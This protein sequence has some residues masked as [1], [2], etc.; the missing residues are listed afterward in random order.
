MFGRLIVSATWLAAF[1]ALAELT[2]TANAVTLTND[3]AWPTTSASNVLQTAFPVYDGDE[4]DVKNGRKHRQSFVL[5]SSL[6]FDSILFGGQDFNPEAD[7]FT[8]GFYSIADPNSSEQSDYETDSLTP[9]VADFLVDVSNGTAFSGDHVLKIGLDSAVTLPAGSYYMAVDSGASGTYPFKWDIVFGDPYPAGRGVVNLNA[10]NAGLEFSM[11]LITGADYENVWSVDGDGSFHDAANWTQG[12]VPTDDAIFGSALS[13]ANAPATITVDTP[14]SLNSLTFQNNSSYVVAG[15]GTITLTGDHEVF[16]PLG[17]HLLSTDLAGNV[18]LMKTGNGTLGLSGA[19]SYTGTTVVQA[20]TLSI[21]SLAAIDNQSAIPLNIAGGAAV[22]LYP[23]VSG[24]LSSELTGAG[25]LRMTDSL[26]ATNAADKVTVSRSNSTFTGIVRVEGG[27]LEISNE[28]ALGEGGSFEYRTVIDDGKSGT[29]SLTGNISIADEFLDFGGRITDDV[30]LSSSGNNAWNGIIRGGSTYNAGDNNNSANYHIE[31][32]SGTLTLQQLYAQ[33]NGHDIDFVFSGAGDT[34]IAGHISDSSIDDSGVVSFSNR[35]D[36]AVTKRGTGT[37]TINTGTDADNTN[38]NNWWFGPTV[39][40]EGTLVVNDPLASDVGELHSRD[41][42]V[43][44]GGTLDVT[45]FNTYSQQIGQTLRGSGTIAA[46][47]LALYDDGSLSPGNSNGQVGT[48]QVNGNVTLGAFATIGTEGAWS[49]DIG[50]S[51]SPESDQLA[52]SGTFTAS[53]SP[54]MMV[55]VTPSAGHLDQGSTTIVAHT[56][57]TNTAMNGVA[58]QITDANGTPL[59]TRQT[60]S[61]S[62]D[63]AG[64]VNLTVTGEEANRTWSGATSGVWDIATTNNWQ[65]GDQQFRDLDQVTFDDSAA[66][67]TN[68]TVDGSRFAGSVTFANSTKAY[69]FSGTGGIVGSGSVNVTGAAQVTLANT[70][71]NYSGT[72]TIDSGSSLQLAS[73]TTGTISNSGSLS[74]T[75]A[76]TGA[77]TLTSNVPW[78]DSPVFSTFAPDFEGDEADVRSDRVHR[79]SFKLDSETTFAAILFGGQDFRTNADD[80]TVS[81]YSMNDSLSTDEADYDIETATQVVADMVVDVSTGSDYTG[82]HVWQLGLSSPITLPAGDYFIALES[83]SSG[84]YAFKWDLDNNRS[85][86]AYPDG[87][88]V[89]NWGLNASQD[90]SMALLAEAYSPPSVLNVDG[91]FDM[92]AGSSLTLRI[93]SPDFHD[94]IDVSGMFTAD[95]TLNIAARSVGLTATEGD[96]F[97]LFLFEEGMASGSFSIGTLPTLPVGLAWDISNLL[98]NGELAVVAGTLPGDFNGDGL[99]NLGDYTVWRDNLGAPESDLPI[100]SYTLGNGTIDAEEYA[101]WKANFG[102]GIDIATSATAVP[103]PS[104]LLLMALLVSTWCVARRK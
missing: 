45:A 1:F 61:V 18:G 24:T 22:D 98:V 79:Q 6:T 26:D 30:A 54:S 2:S 4:S 8:I 81:F 95:G 64:Q 75:G 37:L 78:S 102:L 93:S 29:L 40:E 88:V 35:D 70:G 36:V 20:G 85:N 89:N 38:S 84:T 17:S 15:S 13:S 68:V 53:G 9:V 97:D 67:S 32:T 14:T 5:D 76:Q 86:D 16:T 60:V 80:F 96:V 28:R 23:G 69:T 87:L 63:T 66:G 27:T 33:D 99:V 50:N 62:G 56:G 42:A 72:T 57:A 77:M 58:A 44:S 101:T 94:Q 48:L 10:G 92:N 51:V 73:A 74:L 104:S 3:V 47:T 65:Q 25:I 19:K 55:N 103:E 11:A 82:D 71:N 41:I 12:T 43:H 83:G 52:V 91:D 7:D 90:Y 46:N 49:F 59:N 100:G 21:D 34:V 31:S 39:I